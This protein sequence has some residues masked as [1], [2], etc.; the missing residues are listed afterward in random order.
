MLLDND[1][2]IEELLTL[3]KESK[4][5]KSGSVWVKFKQQTQNDKKNKIKLKLK[6]NKKK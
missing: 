1:K 2:F 3:Y 4:T 5:K 6:L